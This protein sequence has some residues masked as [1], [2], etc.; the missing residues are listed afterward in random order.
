ML[1]RA[2][3]PAGRQVSVRVIAES[4]GIPPQILPSVM[5]VLVRAGLADVQ[6]GRGGGYRLARSPETITL[7]SVIEAVEGDTRRQTCVLRG[8]PCGRDGHCGVHDAFF[9]AEEAMRSQLILAKLDQLTG[10]LREAR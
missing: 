3:A 4:M 5:R 10:P 2:M 7:L 1:A 9:A 6:A 8:G